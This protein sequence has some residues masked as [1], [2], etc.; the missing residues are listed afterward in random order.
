MQN[1]SEFTP[2]EKK[3]QIDIAS[4]SI[5]DEPNSQTLHKSSLGSSPNTSSRVEFRMWQPR[6]DSSYESYEPRQ[7]HNCRE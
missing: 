7:A 1:K 2:K 3:Y 5:Y 4:W 6:G